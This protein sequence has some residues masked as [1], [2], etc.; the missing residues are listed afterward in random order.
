MLNKPLP[1]THTTLL[2]ADVMVITNVMVIWHTCTLNNLLCSPNFQSQNIQHVEKQTGDLCSIYK[3]M[4]TGAKGTET[5]EKGGEWR[6]VPLVF[7]REACAWMLPGRTDLSWTDSVHYY[8]AKWGIFMAA[9]S[10][11]PFGIQ[12][13]DITIWVQ[14]QIWL[15]S[16]HGWQ[17][18]KKQAFG[19]YYIPTHCRGKS[20]CFFVFLVGSVPSVG[21]YQEIINRRWLWH[22]IPVLLV[23]QCSHHHQSKH[24]SPNETS[25][26][27]ISPYSL[28]SSGCRWLILQL[29]CLWG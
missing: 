7:P 28:T 20:L 12:Q 16:P 24:T 21:E 8:G 9:W 11:L 5:D 13:M 23:C 22:F 4:A 6:P 17:K 1:F 14:E 19:L 3:S 29:T 15:Q 2:I 25:E 26:K 27:D 18:S 10:T